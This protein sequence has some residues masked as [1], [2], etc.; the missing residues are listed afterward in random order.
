MG[1]CLS[2]YVR[3]SKQGRP[4]R[5]WSVLLK[6]N[7]SENYV[8]MPGQEMVCGEP[9]V[10]SVWDWFETRGNRPGGMGVSKRGLVNVLI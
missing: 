4:V 5:G 3:A 1:L 7:S 8:A 2:V 9:R 6:K 10:R